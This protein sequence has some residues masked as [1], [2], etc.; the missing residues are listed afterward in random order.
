MMIVDASL[1]P[2]LRPGRPARSTPFQNLEKQFEFTHNRLCRHLERAAGRDGSKRRRRFSAGDGPA[3]TAIGISFFSRASAEAEAFRTDTQKHV[4]ASSKASAC[5]HWGL[6]VHAEQGF[7]RVRGHLHMLHLCASRLVWAC[8][9]RKSSSSGAA[10][11]GRAYVCDCQPC[12][13]LHSAGSRL[14]A[15][16][17]PPA[18]VAPGRYVSVAYRP[19]RTTA[20]MRPESGLLI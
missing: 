9:S 20:V 18:Q 17:G 5:Q 13:S 1:V 19:L 14:H 15:G 10:G 16:L 6:H 3:S 7:A 4:N 11:M 12:K 2:C 8:I